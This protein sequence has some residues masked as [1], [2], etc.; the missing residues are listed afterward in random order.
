MKRLPPLI[1]ILT[2]CG[3]RS[4]S[5]GGNSKVDQEGE[6]RKLSFIADFYDNHGDLWLTTEGSSFNISQTKLR[7]TPMTATG[8]GFL[9]GQCQ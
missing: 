2:A 9:S 7:N 4:V 3:D 8:L 1:L 5:L 6:P